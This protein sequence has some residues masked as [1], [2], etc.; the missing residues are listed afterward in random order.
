MVDFPTPPSVPLPA[1]CTD[2]LPD[3]GVNTVPVPTSLAQTGW[4]KVPGQNYGPIPPYQY[5]NWMKYSTW[6]WLK[7][8]SEA[9]AYLQGV[10]PIDNVNTYIITSTS[11]YTPT[12]QCQFVEVQ[13]F[14]GGGSGSGLPGGAGSIDGWGGGGAGA[15][16]TGTFRVSF[17][18][19]SILVTIGAGGAGVAGSNGNNGG[20]SSFGSLITNVGGGLAALNGRAGVGGAPGTSTGGDLNIA[21]QS[22]T[23]GFSAL[24]GNNIS[25]SGAGGNTIYG[26]GGRALYSFALSPG[27]NGNPGLGYGSG[28]SGSLCFNGVTYAGGNG[29]PGICIIKEYQS[30]F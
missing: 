16:S 23:H 17:L 5:E 3:G 21:G 14:G 9:L 25:F 19:P 2:P 12:P 27:S 10:K 30:F 4:Q 28:G 24:V 13:I 8:A 29:A 15:Y 6:L 1:W 18:S 11:T 7:Y 26:A 22:G 20:S